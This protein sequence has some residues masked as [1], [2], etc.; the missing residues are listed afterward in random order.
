[1][2]SDPSLALVR[3]GKADFALASTRASDAGAEH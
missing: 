2:L 1:M 3:S